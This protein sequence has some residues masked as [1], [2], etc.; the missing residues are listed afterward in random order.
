MYTQ[1]E[2]Y[3]NFRNV[4]KIEVLKVEVNEGDG[5]PNDPVVRV[6]YICSLEGKVLAKMGETGPRLFVGSDEMIKI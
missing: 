2:R 3:S 5:T 4:K 6:A 1:K